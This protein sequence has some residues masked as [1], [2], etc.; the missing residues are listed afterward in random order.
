MATGVLRDDSG[1]LAAIP[2]EFCRNFT[3]DDAAYEADVGYGDMIYPLYLEEN[4]E[5]TT[6]P[7]IFWNNWGKTSLIQF[8]SI[9]YYCMYTHSSKN[10]SETTCIKPTGGGI[11]GN[12]IADFR[13]VSGDVWPGS[14]PQYNHAGSFYFVNENNVYWN[15]MYRGMDIDSAGHNYI[16]VT[17][18]YVADSGN[19]KYSLIHK[20]FPYDDETR[21]YYTID[22]T[23]LKDVKY[24]DATRNF[25]I[26]QYYTSMGDYTRMAWRDADGIVQEKNPRYTTVSLDSDGAFFTFYNN[27]NTGTENVGVI[28]KDY[29]VTMNGENADLPIG[30]YVMGRSRAALVLNQKTLSFKAGDRVTFDVILLPYGNPQ[31]EHYDNV[32]NVF[33]DSVVDPVKTIVT[34]G[35][36]TEDA[37]VPKVYADNNQAEFV[38]SGGADNVAVRIDGFSSDKVPVIEEYVDGSWVPYMY[39]SDLGYDGYSIY[40]NDDNTYGFTYTI[41]METEG[42]SRKFRISQ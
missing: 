24:T 14:N 35:T 2:A 21:N 23:F 22:I 31:Q 32:L 39:Y 15:S 11:G 25:Q 42:A 12:I 41:P 3:G 19:Y 1:V 36:L 6:I 37:F 38:L 34:K 9:Q 7:T 16:D 33:N 28:I 30:M 4:Q 20:E 5:I 10:T 29:S 13:G 27:T 17:L 8:S 26:L 40:Y 18:D